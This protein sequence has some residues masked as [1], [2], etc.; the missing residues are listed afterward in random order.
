MDTKNSILDAIGNTPLVRLNKV[1]EPGSAEVYAKCEYMNPAGSIKDRMAWYIIDQA[2]KQGLL[3]PGGTIV[4]NTSGNT[5]MG[6]AMAAAAKG[7]K[8][9]FTM[10]D[11]M[12][13]EKIDGLRA[14][15]A[16][17]IIT[18]T[19]VPG[20]SPDH[21]V[22]VAKRVA[23]ETP[24]SFYLDQYH[25]QWNIDAHDIMT[26]EEI[27]R[28]TDGGNVDAV[29]AGTGTGGTISGIG[30][31]FKRHGSKAKI[32]GVDPLGSVHYAVF[33]TGQPSTPYVYKVEG[34]GEDIVCRAFDPS[35]V[36]EMHQVND[37]E[38]FTMARRLIREEGLFCGGSSGGMVHIAC[39]LAKEMGPGKKIIVILPDSGT[40]YVTKYLDDAWMKMH[41]FMEEPRG[42]GLIEDMIDAERRVVTA[43]ET[44]TIGSVIALLR[45]HGISQVPVTDADGKPAGIVHE[46]DI[47]RGLQRGQVTTDSPVKSIEA[48][49]G[50]IVHPKA[51]VEELYGIFAAEQAA[52]VMNEGR[53]VAILS[54]ID[55][56][57]HL[58]SRNQPAAV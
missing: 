46:I 43:A 21:Y 3:K 17:V 7:Y 45:D 42:L 24:N 27:Y 41:G 2:E 8:A 28:Q 19:D 31:C 22:N 11:K 14:F 9:V 29:I 25:N 48:K 30:R 47:L 53:V 49:L 5:G 50:G 13:K 52:I 4:E 32:I 36:D 23:S 44:D 38:C 26:G 35:V 12:S 16:Q 1:V 33:H 34:L 54:E 10:P 40:R 37:Y 18:P 15:G 6:A 57:E 39:K 56:I 51:R 58:A 55:L 20:D